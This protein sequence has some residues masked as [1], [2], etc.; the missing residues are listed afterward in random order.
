M[1]ITLIVESKQSYFHTIHSK[2]TKKNILLINLPVCM[3]VCFRKKNKKIE[4]HE[5]LDA[6]IYNPVFVNFYENYNKSIARTN[7]S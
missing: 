2:Q 7:F 5:I 1:K 3:P 4:D 6:V